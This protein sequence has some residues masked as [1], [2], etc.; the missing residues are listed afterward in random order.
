MGLAEVH[1]KV[2]AVCFTDDDT[3]TPAQTEIREG[4][5]RCFTVAAE[6]AGGCRATPQVLIADALNIIHLADG[7]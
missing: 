2:G 4:H 5:K 3:H 1:G 7:H 6:H